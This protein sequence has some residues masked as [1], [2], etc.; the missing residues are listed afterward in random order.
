MTID[1]DKLLK[2]ATTEADT[3]TLMLVVA[4]VRGGG[5]SF[6]GGTAGVP[7]LLLSFGR[8]RHSV[9]AARALGG[10]VA[11]IIVDM[12][13]AGAFLKP[14][15]VIKNV[16]AILTNP[17]ILKKFGCVVF[18]G[19]TVYDYYVNQCT[20]V[21]TAKQYKGSEEIEKVYN[22]LLNAFANLQVSKIHVVATIAAEGDADKATGEFTNITPQLRGYNSCSKVL[23]AF[24]DILC[25]GKVTMTNE[26]G[27]IVSKHMLQFSGSFNKSGKKLSGEA[28]TLSFSC[29]LGGIPSQLLPEDGL[30]PAS[31]RQLIE[32]KK[33][34]IKKTREMYSAKK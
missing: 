29:R 19:I 30:F 9:A 21:L 17:A 25:V 18:D 23:G 15:D 34:T 11:S 27:D 26:D 2:E 7:T 1:F 32:F 8:E 6:L 13:D 33:E 12:D 28:R 10:T 14:D 24:S 5:K 22:E 3:E 4:G 31:L 16:N 20:A